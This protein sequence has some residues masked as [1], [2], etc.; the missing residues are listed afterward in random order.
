MI[1]ILFISDT[2]L[3]F[4]LPLRP[5][6]VK[7]R[8]GYDF[9]RNYETALQAVYNEKIDLVV[10]C[11]DIF[12]R[13]RIPPGLV[14]MAFKPLRRIADT[15]IPVFIVPGNHE[16]SS[17]PHNG[18]V[19]HRNILIF[20]YPRTYTTK[21]R[22]ISLSL[23][24]F[25]FV[26]HDVRS[27]F[28][29]ILRETGWENAVADINIL[30]MHQSVDGAAV[31]PSNYI[32]RWKSD[33]VDIINIPRNLDMVLSGHI[34]RHQVLN[35]DLKGREFPVPILYSGSLERTSFAERS[36]KKGYMIIEARPEKESSWKFYEIETS[37]MVQLSVNAEAM[38][39]ESFCSWL[40][41]ELKQIK[42]DAILKINISGPLDKDMLC[43]LRERSLRSIIPAS[44]HF[45]LRIE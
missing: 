42:P 24:G 32:F 9:F 35:K 21:I 25:P 29:Q 39:T 43:F 34:H 20:D 10:H 3:G 38:G 28:S 5:R 18:L 11:G 31:G 36:E 4:D 41:E 27:K 14:E 23:A 30:C 40:K 45:T 26:R 8:R 13:S 17:I 7:R 12:Y 22:G 15:G 19:Y 33:V 16:R 37:P 2:H 44:M 6:T 1:K